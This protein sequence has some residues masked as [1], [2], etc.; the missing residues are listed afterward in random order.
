EPDV[1]ALTGAST[2]VVVVA[3]EESLPQLTG[4]AAAS[5]AE[6]LGVKLTIFHSHH[7]G[8]LGGEFGQHG[9]PQRFA[10]R[11]HEVLAGPRD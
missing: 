4:R 1:A 8:F 2:R 11:L 10:L 7:G 6:A 3:G 5:L 9:E